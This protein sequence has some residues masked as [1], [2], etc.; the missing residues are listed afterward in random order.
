MGS[1]AT[2]TATRRDGDKRAA[3]LAIENFNAAVNVADRPAGFAPATGQLR[4]RLGASVGL[5]ESQYLWA[6]V[7]DDTE[8]K[9]MCDPNKDDPRMS[10]E[11]AAVYYF[12]QAAEAG[13]AYAMC[14]LGSIASNNR[15]NHASG[16]AS[17]A[18]AAEA[19][20]WW[21]KALATAA[22][23]EAAYNL[24]VC[25]GLGANETAVDLDVAYSYYSYGA[26]IDL[27]AH[28][29]A[30]GTREE[31]DVADCLMGSWGA[32]LGGMPSMAPTGEPPE[33]YVKSNRTNA[34]VVWRDFKKSA[35]AAVEAAKG[36]QSTR[37]Q[38]P[39]TAAAAAA[40]AAAGRATTAAAAVSRQQPQEAA[41]APSVAERLL[42][43]TPAATSAQAATELSAATASQSGGGFKLEHPGWAAMGTANCARAGAG[44]AQAGDGSSSTDEDL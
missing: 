37:W 22:V 6:R 1:K 36:S 9:L 10:R 19:K 41:A 27:S 23:P 30:G 24:G 17:Q 34:R 43:F 26:A 14:K 13:H 31:K 25:H 12:T 8:L 35:A 16:P 44:G 21:R 39:Q 3:A 7:C 28:S 32:A 40:A 18:L 15:E 2:E 20:Q 11:E 5:P 38:Q 29:C 33:E 4:L 42:L